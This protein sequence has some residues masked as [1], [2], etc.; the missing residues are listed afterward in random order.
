MIDAT[1][2]LTLD[3]QTLSDFANG[4]YLVWNIRGSVRFR[5]TR[6]TGPNALL[7]GLFFSPG[8]VTPEGTLKPVGVV[9]GKFHLQLAGSGGSTYTIQS[10]TDFNEWTSISTVTLTSSTAIVEAAM[11]PGDGSQVFRA[12]PVP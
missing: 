10:S 2:G 4:K 6:Q 9:N 3:T 5:F 12:I 7:M 11:P 1:T 8:K